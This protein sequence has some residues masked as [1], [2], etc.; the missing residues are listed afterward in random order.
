VSNAAYFHIARLLGAAARAFDMEL[1]CHPLK[2]VPHRAEQCVDVH[3]CLEAVHLKPAAM[4]IGISS[5]VTGRRAPMPSS[6]RPVLKCYR[7]HRQSSGAAPA[8]SA[9]LKYLKATD[10]GHNVVMLAYACASDHLN[11]QCTVF[12]PARAHSS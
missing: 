7:A 9:W 8:Q 2:V 11:K 3:S 10:Q 6:A 5:I 4:Y 12:T 1:P